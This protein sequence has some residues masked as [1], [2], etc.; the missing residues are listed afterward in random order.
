[1][2]E[3]RANARNQARQHHQ[4][5]INR[6]DVNHHRSPRYRWRGG[7]PHHPHHINNRSAKQLHLTTEATPKFPIETLMICGPDAPI[8]ANDDDDEDDQT[9]HVN[10]S[11]N[12][13]VVVV[14][15]VDGTNKDADR[16]LTAERLKQLSV[17]EIQHELDTQ[18]MANEELMVKFHRDEKKFMRVLKHY[19]KK[20]D[21]LQQD[22]NNHAKNQDTVVHA[23]Q[24]M[25]AL[26]KERKTVMALSEAESFQHQM[27][28]S[29]L[30]Q[31][32]ATNMQILAEIDVLKHQ[33][34]VLEKEN[35]QIQIKEAA[36][37]EE[38]DEK[39]GMDNVLAERKRQRD[40]IQKIKQIQNIANRLHTNKKIIVDTHD[41]DSKEEESAIVK[42]THNTLSHAKQLIERNA[43]YQ[44][45]L[46]QLRQEVDALR[47]RRVLRV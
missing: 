35:A 5:R 27:L 14:D 19:E 4:P 42:Q 12:N 43:H 13:K 2:K 3:E 18:R 38:E 31:N 8:T 41:D 25:K 30:W 26:L 40:K 21:A 16:P 39:N 9:Q 23:A 20:N 36:M 34:S 6:Y 47:N 44:A 15:D 29:A 24:A 17:K 7:P 45:I 28:K 37:K 22:I 11:S 46:T 1:M 10:K 32:G 33:V